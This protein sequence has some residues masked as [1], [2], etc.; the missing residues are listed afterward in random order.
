MRVV[1]FIM[2]ASFIAIWAFFSCAVSGSTSTEYATTGQDA[3]V[4]ANEAAADGLDLEAVTAMVKDAANA[5]ELEKSLNE[6]GGVNNLDLNADGQVDYIKVTEYGDKDAYGFSLTTEPAPSEEQEIA[7]IEITRTDDEA[8][9]QVVGNGHVYGNHHVYHSSH[10]LSNFLLW[11][12]LLSPHSRYHS[13]WYWNSYPSYYRSYSPVPR[14]TYVTR[15][16]S[17]TQ[18]AKVNRASDAT[19]R[20]TGLESPNK[21]KVANTGIR[22][23]LAQPTQ[24]QRQFQARN[25]QK[26][27]RQGGFGQ[28]SRTVRSNSRSRSSSGFGK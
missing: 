25:A 28:S 26:T 11:S 24:T 15:T 2:V 13:P 7:T 4:V 23:S 18:S 27:V 10:S 1:F 8:H 14:T 16:Q 17:Y 5:E 22:K 9:V 20:S 12:Y 19:L 21:G 3:V 6:P